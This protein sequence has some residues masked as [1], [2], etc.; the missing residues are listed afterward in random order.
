MSVSQILQSRNNLKPRM[1]TSLSRKEF[2][3]LLHGLQDGNKTPSGTGSPGLR[4]VPRTAA[5][6]RSTVN[7]LPRGILGNVVQETG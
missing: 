7:G 6:V 4:E 2:H 3:L 1:M 5:T